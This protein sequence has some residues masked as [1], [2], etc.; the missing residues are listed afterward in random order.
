MREVAFI[1]Q[2]KARWIDFEQALTENYVK[3]P[4]EMSRLYIQLV[5]DLAYAQTYYPKSNTTKYLNFLS[6]QV[7]QQIYQIRR[8]DTSR[9]AYF[10]KTEVPLLMIQYRRF[11]IFAF[12]LFFLFLGIGV[13]SA[14]YDEDYARLIMGDGYINMTL[15]NIEKGNPIAVYGQ[16]AEWA[17]F[18]S[19]TMNN[20]QVGMMFFV[21]GIFLG[22]GTLYYFF[23]N[24]IMLGAFQYFFQQHGVLLESVRGVWIHGCMEI[25][26]MI[27]EAMA[28]F[29]LGASILFPDT[30]SRMHS[31]KMGFR[32]SFKIFLS[33]MPFTFFAGV[34]EGFVTR[35]ALVM[36]LALNLCIIFG[37]LGLITFYYLIY[38]TMVYRRVYPKSLNI[39]P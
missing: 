35:Y 18:V 19:I 5:N 22:I 28:G 20:L 27:I 24:V 37:T 29:I 15:E 16:G 1:K 23:R 39:Q 25:F 33:T 34:L 3:S 8:Q 21:N 36:P 38:P 2:N 26:A 13:L 7:F 12:A 32:N 11:L 4:D 17:G 14:H 6:A 30:Y 10:F 9:I 31:F